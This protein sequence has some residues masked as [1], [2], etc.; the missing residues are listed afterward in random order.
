M[1]RRTLLATVGT[2]ST[3]AVAGC[4]SGSDESPGKG[5]ATPTPNP[6]PGL[7]EATLSREGN[8]PSE[9]GGTASIDFGD[10]T[11]TVD[12]CLTARDGCHYPGLAEAVYED[13]VFRIVVEEVDESDPDEVCTQAIE[14]RAYTVA[15]TF[16]D[17][18]PESVEV[19]HDAA[20]GRNT[21]ATAERD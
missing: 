19:V 3:G 20:D 2:I 14:Y 21:V 13:D 8:C 11:V 12:G 17:G 5:E 18:T 6:T 1:K 15:A 16:A 7:E 10:A 4:T 9:D